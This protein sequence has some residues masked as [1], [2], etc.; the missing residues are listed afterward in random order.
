MPET[1]PLSAIIEQWRE[2]ADGCR[3]AAERCTSRGGR[4]GYEGLVAACERVADTV[5]DQ[6]MPAKSGRS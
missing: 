3:S 5:T 1:G 6:L 4:Q 2:R